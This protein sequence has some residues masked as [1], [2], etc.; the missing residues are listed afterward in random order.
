MFVVNRSNTRD[1]ACRRRSLVSKVWHSVCQPRLLEMQGFFRVQYESYS[2]KIYK[3]AQVNLS[4]TKTKYPLG[5]RI[6]HGDNDDSV[7]KTWYFNS[8]ADR[9]NVI[10]LIKNCPTSRNNPD[11]YDQW[12][13][14]NFPDIGYDKFWEDRRPALDIDYGASFCKNCGKKIDIPYDLQ[15]FGMKDG[16]REMLTKCCA[17]P[18]TKY[19]GD[20]PQNLLRGI[21]GNYRTCSLCNKEFAWAW[22][23]KQCLCKKCLAKQVD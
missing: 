1:D 8:D 14:E 22:R 21:A 10:S 17:A 20:Y 2:M 18:A 6:E 7:K 12:I 23:G 15:W 4:N 11:A 13:D 16:S 3:I 9:Q 5:V 19:D